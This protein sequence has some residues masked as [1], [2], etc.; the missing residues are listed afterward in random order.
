VV[1]RHILPADFSYKPY[2]DHHRMNA[3]EK[4]W[5]A[6]KIGKVETGRGKPTFRFMGNKKASV[7]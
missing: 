1:G 2:G 4:G 6:R 3:V 5:P 7:N